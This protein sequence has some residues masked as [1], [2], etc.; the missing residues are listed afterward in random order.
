MIFT[1]NKVIVLENPKCGSH[2]LKSLVLNPLPFPSFSL[3]HLPTKFFKMSYSNPK[4]RHC[5]LEALV[6][7]LQSKNENINSYTTVTTIRN[8]YNRLWSAYK[9]DYY[10][11]KKYTKIECN[12]GKTLLKIDW[13]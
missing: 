12:N 7:Y 8:P 5:N 11:N 3:N 9:V 10:R 6:K 2:T 13:K 1:K 4:Y